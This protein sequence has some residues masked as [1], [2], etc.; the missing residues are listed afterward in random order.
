MGV[1]QGSPFSKERK[2]FGQGV[3]LSPLVF[4]KIKLSRPLSS[5]TFCR[6]FRR[7]GAPASQLMYFLTLDPSAFAFPLGLEGGGLPGFGWEWVGVSQQRD[8]Q[9]LVEDSG[10]AWRFSSGRG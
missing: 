4:I 2:R 10:P 5:V 7:P 9:W 6:R 1:E 8:P 3:E